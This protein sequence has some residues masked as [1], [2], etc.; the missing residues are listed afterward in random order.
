MRVLL[1]W[2]LVLGLVLWTAVHGYDTFLFLT[3]RAQDG[4]MLIS[5][6]VAEDQSGSVIKP[7]FFVA[8]FLAWAVIVAPLGLCALMLSDGRARKES[9]FLPRAS[10]AGRQRREPTLVP[11][12]T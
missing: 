3:D 12:V 8:R 1:F 4:A 9:I 6:F 2:V 5:F 11:P 10:L 7:L